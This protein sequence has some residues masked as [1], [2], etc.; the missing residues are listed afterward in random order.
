MR[1]FLSWCYILDI[2]SPLSKERDETGDRDK[3]IDKQEE[4]RAD[5]T[6]VHDR[7]SKISEKNDVKMWLYA[8]NDE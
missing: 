2:A 3:Q 6:C 1:E 7:T 8:H 5:T 4:K